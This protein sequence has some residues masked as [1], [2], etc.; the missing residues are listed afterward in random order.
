MADAGIAGAVLGG[1]NLRHI[2][3][4]GLAATPEDAN[5]VPFN[6]S[7]VHASGRIAAEFYA[8][9]T[10]EVTGR[11]LATRLHGM[12]SDPGMRDMPSFLIARDTMHQQQWLG[13]IEEVGGE[14]A[15][16]P[17]PNNFPQGQEANHFSYAY[18]GDRIDKRMPMSRWTEGPSL[19]GRG[20]LE[21]MISEPFGGEPVLK[22][23]R[24]DSGARSEQVKSST[25]AP[26]A[27]NDPSPGSS[28]NV[29]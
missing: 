12:T 24:A 10:A 11:A 2:L 26:Q 25:A 15:V 4:T 20:K 13:V 6:A 27:A 21:P 18:F 17:I 22:P 3:S 23:P 1:M 28:P 29:A 9:V 5:G 8:K 16:F 7:H 19:D 14:P